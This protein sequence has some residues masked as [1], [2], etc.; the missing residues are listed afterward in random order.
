MIATVPGKQRVPP[1]IWMRAT[2][3]AAEYARAGEAFITAGRP[4][5]GPIAENFREAEIEYNETAD[6]IWFAAWT[7]EQ[8]V[9]WDSIF[10]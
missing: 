1:K 10:N 2:D 7:S 6:A 5:V 4:S 8:R 3:V 9:E